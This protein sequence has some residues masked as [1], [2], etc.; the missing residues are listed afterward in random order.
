[1][2]RFCTLLQSIWVLWIGHRGCNPFASSTLT[3]C[4]PEPVC[5]STTH[6]FA[7]TSRVLSNATFYNGNASEYDWVLDKGNIMNT[8]SSGGGLVMLLTESNGGTLLSSTRYVHFGTITTRLKTGRWAGVVTAFITMSDI[9]D[10]IDWEFPGA[11]TTQGQTNYFWEGVIPQGPNNGKVTGG[12]QDTYSTYHDYTIDWKP[13]TLTFLVDENVVRTVTRSSTIDS[14]GVAHYPSTPSRIQL[15]IWPAGVN[16]SAPGTIAWSGGMINWNDPDYESAGHF[17]AE[18]QSVQVQCADPV[19]P[20]SNVTSYVYQSNNAD[21]P[22]IAFSNA[23]TL[24]SGT[25]PKFRH[26]MRTAVAIAVGLPFASKI[27]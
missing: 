16:S 20:S 24:I 3:A 26:H 13:D 10:E 4:T 6:V 17:Y 22:S 27:F 25:S 11:N 19:A 12:L 9:K 7:N 8:N 1:M 23:S 18:V 5:E 15:S 21:N 2:P 14:S